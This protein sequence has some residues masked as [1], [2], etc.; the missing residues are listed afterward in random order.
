MINVFLSGHGGWHPNQGYAKVPANCTV[1]FYTH[2]AK[3][4]MTGMERQILRG[5]YKQVERTH[6]EFNMVPNMKL[7]GQP[8][9]WT[10]SAEENLSEAA[11]GKSS[12]IIALD[13]EDDETTLSEIFAELNEGPR[14]PEELHFHWLCCSHVGLKSAGGADIGFNASDFN[15]NKNYQGIAG[16]YR[17]QN[18]RG[19]YKAIRGEL[20]RASLS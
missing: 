19:V 7:Y 8:E 14:V 11:W 15:H 9:A 4:L 5:E 17:N 13:D 20:K 1:Y 16:R 2:F 3:L 10:K 12:T 18:K 6:T